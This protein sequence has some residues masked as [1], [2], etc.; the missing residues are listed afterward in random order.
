MEERGDGQSLD[1][2]LQI[3]SRDLEYHTVG[4]VLELAAD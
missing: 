1:W 3:I 2:V 4:G